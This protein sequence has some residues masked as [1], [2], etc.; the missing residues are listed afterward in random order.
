[1]FQALSVSPII[2]LLTAMVLRD[3]TS[4]VNGEMVLVS[5]A[6]IT[7]DTGKTSWPEMKELYHS[8]RPLKY[9]G[10]FLDITAAHAEVGM[11]V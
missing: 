1:M 5:S 4:A 10:P 11:I 9:S 3:L 7:D 8:L 6:S 2:S